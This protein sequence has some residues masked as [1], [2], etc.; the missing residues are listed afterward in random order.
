MAGGTSSSTEETDLLPPFSPLPQPLSFDI[1]PLLKQEPVENHLD[2]SIPVGV[3]AL[4]SQQSVAAEPAIIV[5][6]R[7]ETI[8]AIT[9]F[10]NSALKIPTDVA[11]YKAPVADSSKRRRKKSSYI[12]F[13]DAKDSSVIAPL[14]PIAPK[15]LVPIFHSRT[16]FMIPSTGGA[17][18]ITTEETFNHLQFFAIPTTATPNYSVSG[19]NK[20]FGTT[21]SRSTTSGSREKS[22]EKMAASTTTRVSD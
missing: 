5:A 18:T 20:S 19:K 17:A 11:N 4:S 1:M 15:G 7:I 12:E 8:S 14:A 16:I 21:T 10:V 9:V 2:G 22:A 13:Y 6:T 3:A